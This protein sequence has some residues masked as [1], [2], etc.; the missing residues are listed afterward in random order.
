MLCNSRDRRLDVGETS[1]S[2]GLP[3]LGHWDQEKQPDRRVTAGQEE[4]AGN[5][6]TAAATTSDRH[7]R[8]VEQHQ[9]G[10]GTGVILSSDNNKQATPPGLHIDSNLCGFRG[11]LPALLDL[12]FL[13]ATRAACT[14]TYTRMHQ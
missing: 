4:Q 13:L 11:H 2:R 8:R 12:Y 9:E 1:S 5:I 3:D 7:G 10:P 14:H 6:T